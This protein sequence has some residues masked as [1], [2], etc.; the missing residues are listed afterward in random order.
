MARSR[1]PILPGEG[2][3]ALCDVALAD[4]EFD[5]PKRESAALQLFGA[6]REQRIYAVLPHTGV[7]SLDF[8]DSRSTLPGAASLRA[9]RGRGH[10]P[11]EVITDDRTRMFVCSDTDY[12]AEPARGGRHEGGRKTCVSSGGETGV[13]G[14]FYLTRKRRRAGLRDGRGG[15]RRNAYFWKDEGGGA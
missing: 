2:R 14:P 4:P 9:L 3:G 1:P 7:V 6:G 10:L 15:R 12:C 8:E 13:S 11:D 5:N